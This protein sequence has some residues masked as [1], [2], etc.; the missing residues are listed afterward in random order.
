MPLTTP[1]PRKHLHTRTIQCRGYQRDDG[2]WDVEGEIVDTKTYAFDNKDRGRVAAGEA[3]HHM[4]VRL[5][6]DDGMVVRAAEAVTE[7]SPFAMCGDIAPA[8]GALVG[9]AVAPGW[10][11]EVLKRLAGAKGCTHVTDLLIG[12]LAVTAYQTIVPARRRPRTAATA[13]KRP[14]LID[15]CHALARTSP[16][17]KREWP[18]Y[19]EEVRAGRSD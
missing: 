14:P 18:D 16:V 8:Y 10:R 19:Y 6:I 12:P 7:A 9:L 3:V 2:L 17:V 13:K 5:T 15:S 1:V 11:K 4:R